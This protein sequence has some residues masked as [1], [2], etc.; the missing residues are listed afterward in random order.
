MGYSMRDDRYR[1]TEWREWATGHRRAT[2]LYD[3]AIDPDET[4]NRAEDPALAATRAALGAQL[5]RQ[6]PPRALSTR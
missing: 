3:H 6:F 2:E 5:A 1:Y 4:I